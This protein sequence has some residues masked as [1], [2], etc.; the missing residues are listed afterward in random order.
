M[1]EVLVERP[2]LDLKIKECAWGV[3]AREPEVTVAVNSPTCGLVDALICEFFKAHG[4]NEALEV[5]ESERK[6]KALSTKALIQK[7]HLTKQYKKQKDC[8]ALEVLIGTCFP[9]KKATKRT[10]PKL[11]VKVEEDQVDYNKI[12]QPGSTP[13]VKVQDAES[14]TMV[15]ATE[16]DQSTPYVDRSTPGVRSILRKESYQKKLNRIR[17]TDTHPEIFFCRMSPSH[18]MS[19]NPSQAVE[20]FNEFVNETP[21]YHE[22]GERFVELQSSDV[23]KYTIGQMVSGLGAD[24]T[25]CGQISK[26]EGSKQCGSAG[27]GLITVDTRPVEAQVEEEDLIGEL[28]AQTECVTASNEVDELMEEFKTIL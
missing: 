6:T 17:F 21:G 24:G 13:K 15:P 20:A 8:A 26:K 10:K 28:L 25:V 7:L 11:K 4:L 2:V 18:L 1:G 3:E 19:P 27:P 14:E 22:T 5:F 9:V 16:K 12:G 23:G